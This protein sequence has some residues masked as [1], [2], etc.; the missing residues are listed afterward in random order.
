MQ[1]SLFIVQKSVK[2]WFNQQ[3]D[4]MGNDG[5]AISDLCL[6]KSGNEPGS[7]GWCGVALSDTAKAE[8]EALLAANPKEAKGIDWTQYDLGTNPEW[9]QT[10]LGQTG[11]KLIV[12]PFPA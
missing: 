8:V 1:H 6:S 12:K 10:R 5:L 4:A 9:P 2:D 7:H 3:A 11:L